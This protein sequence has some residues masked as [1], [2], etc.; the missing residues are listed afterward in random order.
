[1]NLYREALL[2]EI[3]EKILEYISSLD[4]DRLIVNEVLEVLIAHTKHL[5]SRGLIPADA[6]GK[7]LDVLSALLKNPEPLFDLKVEDVH[8][9]IEVYLRNVLGDE[10]GWIAI[11]KSRNDHVA[12]ALRLKTKKLLLVMVGELL[13][14]RTVLL[15]KSR[16]YLNILL[17]VSTHLQPAQVSTVA[18]YLT[19]IEEGLTTYTRLLL[20]I[21]NEV[22]DKSPLGAAAI[23]STRAPIDRRELASLAGFSDIVVNTLLATGSRDFIMISSSIT[24][25]LAVF[26]SR[27]AEDMVIWNTPQFNYIKAPKTHLATSSMMPH[28]KNLVT[29]EVIRAWGGEAIGHLTAI[30]SII[31][32]LPSGYNLDLQEV[33]KHLLRVLQKT[34]EALTVFRDFIE[35]VEFDPEAISRDMSRYLLTVTDLAEAIALKLGRPY[36]DVH[37][38]VAQVIRDLG[39]GDLSKVCEELSRRLGIDVGELQGIADPKSVIDAKPHLGSPNPKMVLEYINEAE[40]KLGKDYDAFLQMVN[41]SLGTTP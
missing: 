18:H 26:L 17:P 41:K 12:A 29:M 3:P 10:A 25:S 7:I 24:A 30:L 9:A 11:G 40:V 2:G 6:G 23:T 8:E 33:T 36:R 27:I 37:R 38:E 32:S 16:N 39:E 15:K 5:M 20:Y 22:I 1:M 4:E 14:L 31:K 34:I 13:K 21:I 19:Y 28:K 35:R